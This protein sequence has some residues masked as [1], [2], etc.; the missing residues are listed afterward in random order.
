MCEERESDIFLP[1]QEESDL[2]ESARERERVNI[3]RCRL[4]HL[5]L[6]RTI[7]IVARTY[8]RRLLGRDARARLL[9]A[10]AV[11]ACESGVY[12]ALGGRQLMGEY[13]NQPIVGFGVRGCD[14]EETRLGWYVWGGLSLVVW[15]GI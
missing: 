1:L 6:I 3:V 2:Q 15:G 11:V 14:E 4:A 9:C 13:N 12:L 8:C 10:V 7:A 5:F